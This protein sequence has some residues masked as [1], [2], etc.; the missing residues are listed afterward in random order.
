M[1]LRNSFDPRSFAPISWAPGDE[2]GVDPSELHQ[3]FWAAMMAAG[4]APARSAP[5]RDYLS[6]NLQRQQQAR[7]LARQQ[8]EQAQYDIAHLHQDDADAVELVMALVTE[9]FLDGDQ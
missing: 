7:E 4:A 8:K 2:S 5:S 1:F 6:E 9:G 3:D